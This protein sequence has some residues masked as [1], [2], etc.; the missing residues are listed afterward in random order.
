MIY[1][2]P[3]YHFL[4]KVFYKVADVYF[5]YSPELERLSL[6]RKGSSC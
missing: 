6:E 4:K 5:V 3:R 2:T 1:S